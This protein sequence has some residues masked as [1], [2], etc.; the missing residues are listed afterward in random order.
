MNTKWSTVLGWVA[1]TVGCTAGGIVGWRQYYYG[2]GGRQER[3]AVADVETARRE[4]RER[5][6]EDRVREERRLSKEAEGGGGVEDAREGVVRDPPAMP[7]DG[8]KTKDAS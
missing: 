2:A 3:E 7:L 4:E 8:K 1:C 6:F 5:A